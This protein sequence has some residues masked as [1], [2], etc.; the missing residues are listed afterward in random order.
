MYVDVRPAY[1]TMKQLELGN[2][3]N[4]VLGRNPLLHYYQGFHDICSV[5]VLVLGERN[6]FLAAERLALFYLRDFMMA[7]LDPAM[8]HLS[9]VYVL[10][11]HDSPELLTI[12]TEYAHLSTCFRRLILR[13]L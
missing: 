13:V 8:D 2:V 3:I 12:L 9:L 4:A 11:R 6:A 1:R 10:L 5:L 7:T